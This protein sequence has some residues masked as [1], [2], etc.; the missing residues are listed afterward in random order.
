MVAGHDDGPSP[1]TAVV[2]GFGALAVWSAVVALL[3]LSLFG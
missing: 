1:L 2:V 3:K